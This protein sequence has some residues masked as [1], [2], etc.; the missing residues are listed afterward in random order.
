V[1]ADGLYRVLP[2]SLHR[3]EWWLAPQPS[4]A[5]DLRVG[6][7]KRYQTLTAGSDGRLTIRER[8]TDELLRLTPVAGSGA[9]AE[10]E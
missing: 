4:L 10:A 8:F 7:G 6:R 2:G 3:A 1:I 5:G 9:A